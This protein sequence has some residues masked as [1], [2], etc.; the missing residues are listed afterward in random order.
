VITSLEQTAVSSEFQAVGP[1]TEKLR[2]PYHDSRERGI[3]KSRREHDRRHERPDAV[4]TGMHMYVRYDGAV[5]VCDE[6][7][8][9]LT[10]AI[11]ANLPVTCRCAMQADPLEKD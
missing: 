10:R 5:R 9:N 11:A 4:E 3:L 2:D 8:L 1:D 7:V 6:A